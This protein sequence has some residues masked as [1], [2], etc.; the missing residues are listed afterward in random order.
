VLHGKTL[1]STMSTESLSF[2]AYWDAFVRAHASPSLRRLS[3]AATS[4]GIGAATA[5]FITRRAVFL[6]LSPVVAFVPTWLARK[7]A[8]ETAEVGPA[9]PLFFA[10]A[11]LK[12]WH[13]TLTGALE[14]EVVRVT[15][16]SPPYE[17]FVDEELP[18]PNM[19][20]D[21]TLH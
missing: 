13:L 14:A 7:L 5:F 16:A 20:T 8:G 2:E 3:F 19:V 17:P 18:R 10:A 11:S 1:V 12:L 15:M 21:H 9:H 4:A 6:V